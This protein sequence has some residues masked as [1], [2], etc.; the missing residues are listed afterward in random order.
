MSIL[1][2]IADMVILSVLWCLYSLPLVTIGAA[3]AAMY[4]TVVKVIFQGRG[5]AFSTFR[6]SF[7]SSFRWTTT[8]SR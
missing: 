4:H 5:Y 3:S 6:D 8:Q 1:N 2:K 7:R